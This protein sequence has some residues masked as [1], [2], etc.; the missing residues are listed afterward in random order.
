[1][2]KEE[3]LIEINKNDENQK[4]VGFVTIVGKTNAG[5]STLINQIFK[6]KIAIA[7]PKSNTTR[8]VINA[9]YND[10]ESQISFID[11]P[12]FLK[13]KTK[14]DEQMVEVIRSS[15]KD[16]DII[17]FLLS[18][19]D[20]IDK[21]YLKNIELVNKD[22][23]T[24]LLINKIDLISKEELFHKIMEIDQMK[25]F[26]EIIPISALKNKNIDTLISVIKKNLKKD[27]QY[28]PEDQI[29]VYSKE[30]YTSEIIRE[31]ILFL[32]EQEVPHEIFV[33][34]DEF[35]EEEE[36]IFIRAEIIISR[37]SLKKIIIGKDGAM[38]K[39]IGIKSRIELERHFNKKISLQTFVKTRKNWKNK[40]SIIKKFY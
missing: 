14:L 7:T 13:V 37:D 40:E 23:K 25:I 8:N 15:L 2:S 19:I 4:K 31:K 28:Y 17:L 3:T 20:K 38:I 6:S 33:S 16:V 11:T 5:K 24:F 36:K 34:I 10:Q 39:E 26:D 35:K 21:E 12:G 9:I 1:M 30:F 32:L 29:T 22:I 27:F 18:S